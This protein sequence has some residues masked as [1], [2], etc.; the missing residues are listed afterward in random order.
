MHA[1]MIPSSTAHG[2]GASID[3]LG[4]AGT[5][6][7]DGYTGGVGLDATSTD[8]CPGITSDAATSL[9]AGYSGGMTNPYAMTVNARPTAA[10]LPPISKTGRVG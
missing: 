7:R 5:T 6:P 4:P 2:R 8:A 10:A 3:A 1:S 9:G